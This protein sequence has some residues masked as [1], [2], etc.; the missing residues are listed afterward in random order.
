MS[1]SYV[2]NARQLRVLTMGFRIGAIILV[3]E[4]ISWV[5][6]IEGDG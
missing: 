6:G 1:A 4:V 5:V 3:G 2:A